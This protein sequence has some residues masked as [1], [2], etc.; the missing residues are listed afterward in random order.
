[1]KTDMGT[2]PGE[3]DSHSQATTTPLGPSATLTGYLR[4]PG[5]IRGLQAGLEG[6][7][8]QNPAGI[9]LRHPNHLHSPGMGASGAPPS[10]PA[11]GMDDDKTLKAPGPK[12]GPW[13]PQRLGGQSASG[14][15]GLP[16]AGPGERRSHGEQADA[17]GAR[18]K[19]HTLRNGSYQGL[20]E[21][22]LVLSV[23]TTSS[24]EPCKTGDNIWEILKRCILRTTLILMWGSENNTPKYATLEHLDSSFPWS[25]LICP[26]TPS[27]KREHVH[28]Q[29]STKMSLTKEGY[30]LS[31]RRW[32]NQTP[33]LEPGGTLS[34]AIVCSLGSFFGPKN[35][36][37]PL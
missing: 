9:W 20:G 37:L 7:W 22:C 25:P 34:Q 30:L 10:T 15:S 28:L 2:I 24:Q 11:G 23:I 18:G 31:P 4:A 17:E 16:Q 12:N 19:S 5:L 14:D 6:T 13:Q 33:H 3:S 35:H 21:G 29:S 26:E 27:A 32:K 8:R 36:L 1:M